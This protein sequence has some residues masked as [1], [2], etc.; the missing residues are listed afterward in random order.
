MKKLKRKQK[1][2]ISIALISISSLIIGY[3]SISEILPSTKD[4]VKSYHSDNI[5]NIVTGFDNFADLKNEVYNVFQNFQQATVVR[6]KDGDTYVLK[7]QGEEKTVR[8]IGVDTPE[9]VAPENYYKENTEEG[10]KISDI[11]K[12]KIKINDTVYVEYDESLTDKYGRTLAYVY[13]A[14]GTMV[15]KWLLTNGYAKVMTV[16]PNTKYAE[17]FEKYQSEAQQFEEGLWKEE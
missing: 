14:D 8:L 5:S 16:E 17:L 7:I 6:I 12:E 1:K 4:L 15:Q 3:C 13:F 9:S 11:V 2:F 10:K